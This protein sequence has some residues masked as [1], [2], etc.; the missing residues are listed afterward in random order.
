MV[1]TTTRP[2]TLKLSETALLPTATGTWKT[3]AFYDPHAKG[4]GETH[5]ALVMGDVAGKDDVLV[6]VQ[7][8]C[9]TSEV[10]GSR[11]CDCADQLRLAMKRIAKAKRGVVVYL[12]QEGR[13]IGIFNKI[14]A[15]HLQDHGLDT[16]EANLRLGLPVDAREY[17]PAA[18]I[19][20]S[21]GVRSIALMSNNP[22][23]ESGLKK[24]RVKIAK[25]VPL[26]AAPT[27]HDRAYL[28][29]KKK[30]MGHDL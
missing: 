22:L 8:E 4:D 18:R 30:K 1:R 11:R 14:R 21:L 9:M 2:G 13:G 17:R 29:T 15:Y 7:S 16:V 26:R 19:L 10:F 25:R 28:A 3:V 5:V 23:K 27:P 24:E 6:R 12:R 20:A